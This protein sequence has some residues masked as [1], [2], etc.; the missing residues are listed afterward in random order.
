[1]RILFTN[2]TLNIKQGMT[3]SGMSSQRETLHVVQGQVWVTVEGS[4]DDYWL[5]A[6]DSMTMEADRLIVIEAHRGD[7]Q[8]FLSH[9][10][11]G[12]ERADAQEAHRAFNFFSGV[13]ANPLKTA[14]N[15]AESAAQA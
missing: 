7:G 2:S 15:D 10:Q 9:E 3:V 12:N 13:P 8:V 6:G 1:M 4:P 11:N 14:A 5:S